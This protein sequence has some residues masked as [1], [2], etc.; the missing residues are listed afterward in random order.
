[1]TETDSPI[2]APHP[3]R[4]RLRVRVRGVVQG[5]GFR[6]FVY[7][8][9]QKLCLGGWVL[10]DGEGVLLEAE[11]EG[12]AEFLSALE[13]EAPPLARIAAIET[14]TLPPLGE[15]GFVIRE[16]RAASVTTAIPPDSAVCPDCLEELFDPSARRYRYPFLNCTRC[17]PRYTITRRLPYDRAQTAMAG[18]PLCPDCARE[19]HDPADRRFHA[20][21][22]ACPACGPRLFMPVEEILERLRAGDIVAIKGLGG[23]HLA[24]DARNEGA[25]ATL[26]R[27]KNRE[28]KPFA[29]MVANLPSVRALVECDDAAAA[30]LESAARPILLLPRLAECSLAPSVAPGLRALGIMLPYTPLHYL[31]FH[32]AAGR[33]AGT[34]WLG[35]AQDLT[36][37]MTSANPGGEPLVTGNE[38]AAQRLGGI[39]DAIAAHDRDIIIRADDSVMRVVAG[40][41]G[42]IRRARGFVPLPIRLARKVP[43][44]LAVGGYLKSTLCITRGD[45]AFVSQHIGDL[46]T[47]ASLHFFEETAAHLLDILEVRPELVAHDLHP[48]FATTRFAMSLGPPC[49]AVQH[50]HAH[51]GAILAEHRIEAPVLGLALDGFGLGSDGESWGGEL[52]LV[53]GA[54]WRRLGHLAKLRQPGGEAA[55][56]QPWRMAASVLHRLGRGGEILERFG[57]EK[58]AKGVAQLLERGVQVPETTSCGRLFDAACGLLGVQRNASFEGQAPMR[59]EALVETPRVLPDGW[60]IED[61]VL[62]LLALLERL[63]GMER[64]EGAEL[65][66]GTLAAALTDW[67]AQAAAETGIRLVALG[68]GCLLNQVLAES[69]AEE[70]AGRGLQPLLATQLPPNDGGISLGQA[71]I[72]ALS[73]EKEN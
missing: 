56:R 31:L 63:I 40:K 66:H 53:D 70:L 9:A 26:R 59:L 25:V 29:V 51:I 42:F 68:G 14:E 15:T 71:W 10:N 44:I 54:V 41:P 36:L 34:P 24:C 19:F 30:L 35:T 60:R 45:E 48:D 64:R 50:H 18:F 72:A 22:I 32:E 49:V 28:E 13:T 5:V 69:M 43:P 57:E 73:L 8:L 20:Q 16:S 61:G 46:E 23:F 12:I 27:R 6:P 52:L 1:V 17:G 62:D 47:Q 58:H 7:L 2:P 11:G 65:F 4:R 67:V 33:P 55:A 3:P 21:P 39:A 38:E 37:V